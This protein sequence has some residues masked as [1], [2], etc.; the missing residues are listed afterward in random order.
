MHTRQRRKHSKVSTETKI[1]NI[2]SGT[3]NIKGLRTEQIH[4]ITK[5]F[6]YD[7]ETGPNIIHGTFHCS[8]TIFPLNMFY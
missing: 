6:K 4:S 1:T 8:I 5:G 7:F 2:I 3:S